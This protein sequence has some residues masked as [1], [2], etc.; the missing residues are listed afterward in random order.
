MISDPQL[1]TVGLYYDDCGT[2]AAD[3]LID[4]INATDKARHIDQIKLGYK[5]IE[6]G[7]V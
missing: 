4:M 3:L 1:T 6:R 5:I 7:S 2:V